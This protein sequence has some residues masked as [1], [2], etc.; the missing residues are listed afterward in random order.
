M[1]ARGRAGIRPPDIA[2][3]WTALRTWANSR[4][5]SPAC[6]AGSRSETWS[7][8]VITKIVRHITEPMQR[9]D[10]S[11]RTATLAGAGTLGVCCPQQD[12]GP[13]HYRRHPELF[14]E[15]R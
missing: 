2:A 13:R 8:I 3:S 4:G 9:G 7:E 14:E 1:T 10:G 15:R 6:T 11:Q 12:C 5:S